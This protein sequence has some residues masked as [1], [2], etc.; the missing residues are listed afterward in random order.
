[1]CASST[2]LC[3]FVKWHEQ[4]HEEVG[5]SE[6]AADC[7]AAKHASADAVSAILRY[8]SATPFTGDIA[9]GS[10]ASRYAT[11]NRCYNER[12]EASA[13]SDTSGDNSPKTKGQRRQCRKE[14]RETFDS[15]ERDC[16][17]DSDD[18]KARLACYRDCRETRNDALK[19]CND[20]SE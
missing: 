4:G 18:T 9:H 1:M 14:A 10:G 17:L 6:D 7:Y 13:K 15:C 12:Q 5:P 11:I 19:S 8:F 16:S 20:D 3:D 2:V